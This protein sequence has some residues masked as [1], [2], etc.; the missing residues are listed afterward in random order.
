[1]AVRLETE[2][3]EAVYLS[4]DKDAFGRE[5]VVTDWDQGTMTL[6]QL[7]RALPH[8]ESRR[9]WGGYLWRGGS[10]RIFSGRMSVSDKQK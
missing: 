10:R 2:A 6:E 1:M 7:E 9:F 5:E 3:S 4:I 8:L